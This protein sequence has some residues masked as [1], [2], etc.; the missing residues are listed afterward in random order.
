MVFL[1]QLRLSLTSTKAKIVPRKGS[2]TT[3]T[4]LSLHITI[5]RLASYLSFW[6]W[7]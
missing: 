3:I 7:R 2:S 6:V 4:K 5:A 1:S